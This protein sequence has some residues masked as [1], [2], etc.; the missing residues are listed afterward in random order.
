[1]QGGSNQSRPISSSPSVSVTPISSSSA[2]TQNPTAAQAAVT[3]PGTTQFGNDAIFFCGRD[4]RFFLLVRPRCDPDSV[5]VSGSP[6]FRVSGGSTSP[7]P[8]P[9]GSV[10]VP[11]TSIPTVLTTGSGSSS[12]GGG[13]GEGLSPS[14]VHLSAASNQPPIVPKPQSHQ[15]VFLAFNKAK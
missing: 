6:R 15:V 7:P 8:P 9:V 2:A 11:S 14:P 3:L 4:F 5:F 13:R 12:N 1:M 10:A